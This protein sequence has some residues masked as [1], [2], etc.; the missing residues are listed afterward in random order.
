[1]S[2]FDGQP[3]TPE[4][5]KKQSPSTSVTWK[6]KKGRAYRRQPY[7]LDVGTGPPGKTCA[8]CDH[9]TYTEFNRRYYKCKRYPITGGPGTQIAKFDAACLHFIPITSIRKAQI[10]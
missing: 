4:D 6:D 1:M 3:L 5:L 10:S 8:D 7:H 2:L 9:L